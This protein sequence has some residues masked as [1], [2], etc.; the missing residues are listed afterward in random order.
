MCYISG[1]EQWTIDDHLSVSLCA[2]RH[3]YWTLRYHVYVRLKEWE[4]L[5][6]LV[7]VCLYCMLTGTG[8]VLFDEGSF[9]M[10][11][12]QICSLV[13]LVSSVVRV[14]G[15]TRRVI[16]V[17]CTSRPGSWLCFSFWKGC[18]G[19]FHHTKCFPAT[20]SENI[21]TQ[22]KV[23]PSRNA[24]HKPEANVRVQVRSTQ[25]LTPE[26]TVVENNT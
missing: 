13:A 15:I 2:E 1:D 26:Y 14:V 25:L 24:N 19:T 7:T 21:I 18:A 12:T 11:E 8:S 22:S 6:K 20:S 3:D 4:A 23:H 17:E 10:I 5:T 16:C 9:R